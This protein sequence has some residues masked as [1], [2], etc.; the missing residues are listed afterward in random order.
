VVV[1]TGTFDT[2]STGPTL[3]YQD[4]KTNSREVTANTPISLSTGDAWITSMDDLVTAANTSGAPAQIFRSAMGKPGD[5][6]GL[7]FELTPAGGCLFAHDP[8]GP[9]WADGP[10]TIDLQRIPLE[11]DEGG[12][13]AP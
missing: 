1:T 7:S 3:L 13:V 12:A 8:E 2:V 9:S 4:G 11:K 10:V 5:Q 6:T